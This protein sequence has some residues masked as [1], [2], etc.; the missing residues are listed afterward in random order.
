MSR[1]SFAWE[2]AL[3][4]LGALLF[5]LGS[6]LGLVVAPPEKYMGDVG[7]ILYIHVP[8]AWIALVTFSVAFVVAIGSLWRRT[9]RWDDVLAGALETGTVLTAML[10]IQG[11]LW[12]KPTWGVYWVW[13]PR[14]TTSAILLVAFIAVL[15]LRRFVEDPQR[16]AVW[17]AVATIMAYVDVPIVY[18]SIKW[19]RTMH[20]TFSTPETVAASMKLP[21]RLNAFALLFIAI[22]LIVR[23][24]RLSQLQRL[25]LTPTSTPTDSARPTLVAGDRADRSTAVG[26]SAVSA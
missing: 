2:H 22:W 7:R 12:A 26:E 1:K 23:R 20:Q 10:L 11:S 17:S 19:W 16:R 18:F 9:P 4:I 25:R 14:L 5:C 13:D 24:A 15:A 6:Y 8:T 3:G 21:L